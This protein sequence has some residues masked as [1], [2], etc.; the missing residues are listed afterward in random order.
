MWLLWTHVSSL[1]PF[2]WLPTS[3]ACFG[4]SNF[5]SSPLSSALSFL[6]PPLPLQSLCLD[7]KVLLKSILICVFFVTSK[8]TKVNETSQNMKKEKTKKILLKT[9]NFNFVKITFP[10]K[11]WKEY[12]CLKYWTYYYYCL[13]KLVYLSQTNIWCN[14]PT[15]ER[16]NVTTMA[17]SSLRPCV[18]AKSLESN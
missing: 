2:S 18:L 12:L 9:E 5:L 6:L 10:R 1:S 13:D 8:G 15:N 4:S 17:F 14:L 7:L 11:H 3:L 16:S